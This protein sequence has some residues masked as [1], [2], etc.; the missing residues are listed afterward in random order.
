MRNNARLARAGAGQNKQRPRR[1]RNGIMLSGVESFKNRHAGSTRIVCAPS[2]PGY[3]RQGIAA[4]EFEKRQPGPSGLSERRR[5]GAPPYD[6]YRQGLF[7]TLF[8][9]GNR[10][11]RI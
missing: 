2:P 4:V 5:G 11:Q 7:L 8:Q 1:L 10:D 9:N 3:G 6:A